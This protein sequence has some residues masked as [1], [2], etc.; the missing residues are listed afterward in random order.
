MLVF[1]IFGIIFKS[2]SIAFGVLS[3]SM[4]IVFLIAQNGLLGINTRHKYFWDFVRLMLSSMI[5]FLI[6]YPIATIFGW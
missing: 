6:S 3:I 2:I 1:E 4:L 5:I